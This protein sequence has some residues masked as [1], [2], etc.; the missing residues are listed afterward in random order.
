MPSGLVNAGG[1]LAVFGPKGL[2]VDIRDPGHPSRALCRI[3]LRDAAIASSGPQFNP[4]RS[5]DVTCPAVIDPASGTPVYAVIGATVRA[6]SCLFADALTKVVMTGGKTSAPLL[7][8]FG[9][10]ALFVA[11]DGA[12]HITPEWRDAASLAA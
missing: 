3:E 6:S 4:L 9:A 5:L 2:M 10:S 8:H 11:A 12:V 1:D 7:R